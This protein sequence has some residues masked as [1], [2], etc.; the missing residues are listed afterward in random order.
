MVPVNT[1]GGVSMMLPTTAPWEVGVAVGAVV[2]MLAFP[3][4]V[5]PG[6]ALVVAT[7]SADGVLGLDELQAAKSSAAVAKESGTR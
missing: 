2:S 6:A 1:S 3:L 4:G 7:G 5:L